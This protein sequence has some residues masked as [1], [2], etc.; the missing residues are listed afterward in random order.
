ME[1][2]VY[3]N[4]D[5]DKRRVRAHT[6]DCY[7]CKHGHLQSTEWHGPFNSV[8]K[9]E[10][11]TLALGKFMRSV[12]GYSDATARWCKPCGNRVPEA[13]LIGD[14]HLDLVVVDVAALRVADEFDRRDGG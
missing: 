12:L 4:W 10:I 1:Y 7:R 3:E 9:A 6:K 8:R 13:R 5:K 11:V 14:H 2:W